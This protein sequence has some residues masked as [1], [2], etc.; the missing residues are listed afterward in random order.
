MRRRAL[1][2]THTCIIRVVHARGHTKYELAH[3]KFCS[4]LPFLYYT[5]HKCAYG[6]VHTDFEDRKSVL[7]IHISTLSHISWNCSNLFLSSSVISYYH[8]VY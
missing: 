1:H 3:T 8:R 5:A 2:C 6:I 7:L 4:R